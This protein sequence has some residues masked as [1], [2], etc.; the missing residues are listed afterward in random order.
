[1]KV[2][3]F[4]TSLISGLFFLISGVSQAT[5]IVGGG[6]QMV[7]N[8]DYNYTIQLTLYFD[9]IN[10]STGAL[11]SDVFFTI[12]RK[13]DNQL[14]QN[15]TGVPIEV[16]QEIINYNQ[17]ACGTGGNS[18]RTRVLL[19]KTNVQLS[20]QQYNHPQGYYVVWERCCRNNGITNIVSPGDVG[21]TFVM[22]FPPVA[23]NNNPFLNDSPVFKPVPNTLFCI[24]QPSV[25]DFSAT[26]YDGDS[27]VFDLVDPIISK[28]ASPV[29]PRI[30]TGNSAPYASVVWET[31]FSTFIQIQGSPSLKINPKTG[32]LTLKPSMLGLFVFSVRCSEYRNG[33]KIGEVRREFQQVVIS[34]PANTPPVIT[35]SDPTRGRVLKQ[36]DTIFVNNN[37]QGKTCITV[38]VSD[39]QVQQKLTLRAIPLNFTPISPITGD[40]VKLVV[41]ATDTA[42][43]SFCLP[44]CVGSTRA[45]PFH[46][47]VISFDN[48][49]AGSLFDSLDIYIVLTVPPN[50]IPKILLNTSDSVFS[51]SGGDS[52][53]IQVTTDVLPTQINQLSAELFNNRNVAISLSSLGISF[54]NGSGVGPI[55]RNLQ[56]K[57]PCSPVSNQPLRVVF[58]ANTNFCNQ[59]IQ[60]KKTVRFYV[61]PPK[62]EAHIYEKNKDTAATRIEIQG[63]S[64]TNY[65][66]AL[67][68]K[69][70]KSANISLSPISSQSLLSKYGLVF[71]GASGTSMVESAL[72][73]SPECVHTELTYPAEFLFRATNTACNISYHD[74]LKLKLDLKASD[75]F[76]FHGI[77]LL[78]I[79]NDNKNEEWN[80]KNLNAEPGCGIQFEGLSIYD[81]WGKI[82][83]RTTDPGFT[84]PESNKEEGV[85]FY[86]IRFN[87]Q[88]FTGWIEVRR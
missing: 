17:T 35:L 3:C 48:G 55:S 42:R 40:T 7:A 56:W 9:E 86:N 75:K 57:S 33:K 67:I 82:A 31:G 36:N 72:N 14:M 10:G 1:M 64:G 54:P 47:R 53:K 39:Q 19:Y 84:W 43:L 88:T 74:T 58:T 26:D 8:G 51:V 50:F 61:L 28:E 44:A 63:Y 69:S 65:L 16:N 45:K 12:F 59:N 85:Y 24:N 32:I 23:I 77:N 73:W 87:V 21:Q 27:L 62:G 30:E 18:V 2:R 52:L 49:C 66:T 80:L 20:A 79:N 41:S 5:H 70:R 81:R 6:F 46:L 60:L 29:L 78:T 37:T 68:G 4:L 25:I 34:C 76:D 71:T 13:S 11:D 22:E 83:F 15:L 38:K